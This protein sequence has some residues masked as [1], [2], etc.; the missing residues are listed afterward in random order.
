MHDESGPRFKYNPRY[1]YIEK[2]PDAGILKFD[3][4]P[5]KKISK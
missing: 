4:S 2:K 5:K 1:S 3:Y